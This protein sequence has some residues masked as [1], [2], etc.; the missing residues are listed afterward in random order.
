MPL[1]QL[2]HAAGAVQQAAPAF[3]WEIKSFPG[4]GDLA[5]RLLSMDRLESEEAM[6][7]S[8]GRDGLLKAAEQLETRIRL[9]GRTARESAR[10]RALAI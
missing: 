10:P 5:R 4:A 7:N 6:S 1:Q 8:Q 3:P 2:W 9:A